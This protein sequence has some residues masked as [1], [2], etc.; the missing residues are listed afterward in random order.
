MNCTRC[1]KPMFAGETVYAAREFE[2]DLIL[3]FC[4]YECIGMYFCFVTTEITEDLVE[5]CDKAGNNQDRISDAFGNWI[6]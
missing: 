2:D 5:E 1:H 6:G 4:S 3:P